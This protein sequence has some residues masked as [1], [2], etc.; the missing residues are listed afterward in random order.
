MMP[1]GV[2]SGVPEVYSN[3]SPG[4]SIGV[5]PTT[6]GPFTSCVRPSPSVIFQWRL[7][8]CTVTSPLFS[9]RT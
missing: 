3:T 6:P 4:R 9:M 8:N 7:R 1:D 5:L 2:E